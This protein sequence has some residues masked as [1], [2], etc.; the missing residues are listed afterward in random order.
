MDVAAAFEALAADNLLLEP[1]VEIGALLGPDQ[2]EDFVDRAEGEEEL[3]EEHLPQ[4]PSRP[5]YQH[6]LVPVAIIDRHFNT[7]TIF[8][9][10]K[11]P[12][13]STQPPKKDICHLGQGEPARKKILKVAQ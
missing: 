8:I 4:E 12:A 2:H 10:A 6:P 7:I 9:F 1:L 13:H 5:R 3:L 11:L